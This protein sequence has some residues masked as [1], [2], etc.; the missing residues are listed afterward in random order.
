[1]SG[2]GVVEAL[3]AVQGF[4]DGRLRDERLAHAGRAVT[5]T[6]P[7]DSNTPAAPLP[8]TDTAYTAGYR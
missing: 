8:E 3:P 1:M 7:S 2:R 6:P 4:E 5:S